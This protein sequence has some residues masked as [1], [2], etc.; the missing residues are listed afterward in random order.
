MTFSYDK[1]KNW[2]FKES[3]QTY[4]QKDTILYSLGIGIGYD[5]LDER[6]LNY[7]YEEASGFTAAPTMAVVLAGPGFWSRDPETGIDWKKILHGEQGDRDPQSAAGHC[8]GD[9]DNRGHGNS[10]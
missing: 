2:P 4:T 6:Q 9:G 7:V 3:E 8:N 5:P 10:G 1:I